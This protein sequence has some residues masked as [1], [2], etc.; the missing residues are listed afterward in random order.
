MQPRLLSYGIDRVPD[1]VLS[2]IF[3]NVV[4]DQSVP[5]HLAG[6]CQRFRRVALGTST[7]WRRITGHMTEDHAWFRLQRSGN[8]GLQVT[9]CAGACNSCKSTVTILSQHYRW[10]TLSLDIEYPT[11]SNNSPERWLLSPLYLPTLTHLKLDCVSALDGVVDEGEIEFEESIENAITSSSRAMT[12]SHWS[13]PNLQHLSI[14]NFIPENL[15]YQSLKSLSVHLSSSYPLP[16]KTYNRIHAILNQT[17]S[18]ETFSYTVDFSPVYHFEPPSDAELGL[19]TLDQLTRLV[20]SFT[21]GATN[22]NEFMAVEHAFGF[23][24][25]ICVPKLEEMKVLFSSDDS[26]C[27]IDFFGFFSS[28]RWGLYANLR[29]LEIVLFTSSSIDILRDV[30]SNMP[31]IQE[32]TLSGKIPG[33]VPQSLVAVQRTCSLRKFILR[34]VE[35]LSPADCF[36]LLQLFTKQM[37]HS[38]PSFE[39]FIIRGCPQL[40][41]EV[42]KYHDLWDSILTDI[43]EWVL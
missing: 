28:L 39:W 25:T 14:R 27:L 18:L 38:F 6:V 9:L 12:P 1:E 17:S 23:T 10:K 13:M 22:P 35:G 30:F 33:I 41:P 19:L 8:V 24:E 37:G 7:L 4:Q 42:F 40:S 29:C 11:S 31:Q 32:I 34:R 5:M 3:E 21:P 26:D 36:S 43:V 16:M 2:M 15:P 20:V